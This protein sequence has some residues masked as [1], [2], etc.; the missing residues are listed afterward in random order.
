MPELVCTP[1]L[2]PMP[3]KRLRVVIGIAEE[4][5][6]SIEREAAGADDVLADQVVGLA[7]DRCPA[8]WKKNST[9]VPIMSE[10]ASFSAPDSLR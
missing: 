2:S 3:R 7:A 10:N 1:P 4:P 6:F 8:G 9:L 5:G